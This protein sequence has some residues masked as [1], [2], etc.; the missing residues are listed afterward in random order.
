MASPRIV[1][2]RKMKIAACFWISLILAGSAIAIAWGACGSDD[3]VSPTNENDAATSSD[4]A[5][6]VDVTSDSSS[7]CAT[8]EEA[9]NDGGCVAVVPA[10]ARK[11]AMEID[12]P[13]S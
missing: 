3:N 6:G 9:T 12:P 13:A 5:N 2:A 8:T 4:V 7:G 11:L 1:H 10:G